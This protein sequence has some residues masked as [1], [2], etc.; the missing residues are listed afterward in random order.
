M[1]TTA[2]PSTRF[3]D[4]S[5]EYKDDLHD[6]QRIAVLMDLAEKRS[7]DEIYRRQIDRAIRLA[8]EEGADE[9]NVEVIASITRQSVATVLRECAAKGIYPEN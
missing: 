6:L 2:P 4:A 8:R 9:S 3:L 7:E 5:E 1:R